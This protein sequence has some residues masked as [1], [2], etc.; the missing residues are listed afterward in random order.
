MTVFCVV[1]PCSLVEVYQRFKR[2]SKHFYQSTRRNNTEYSSLHKYA[3]LRLTLRITAYRGHVDKAPHILQLDTGDWLGIHS[4]WCTQRYR[5][6][7]GSPG[8]V[9]T[10]STILC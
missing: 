2:C 6:L 9:M 10:S 5:G 7:C 8:I 4:D 3:F 1:A